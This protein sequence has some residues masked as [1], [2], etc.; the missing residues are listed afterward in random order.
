MSRV[1]EPVAL[2]RALDPAASL[3]EL[4]APPAFV[5]GGGERGPARP[6]RPRLLR[7]VVPVAAAVSVAVLV[8]VIPQA[9]MP[10]AQAYAAT[11]AALSLEYE[12]EAPAASDVLLGLAARLTTVSGT[13]GDGVFHYVRT[14]QWS[15][16]ITAG[17]TGQMAAAWIVP[18]RVELWRAADGSGRRIVTTLP[19]ESETGAP[20]DDPAPPA[21]TDSTLRRGGLA[22][23]VHDPVPTEP[24]LLAAALYAHQPKANGPKSAIRAVA[25]L[26]RYTAVR[27]E[28][29]TAVLA[30]LAGVPELRYHGQ[31]TD[32]LGRAGVAVGVDSD[33]GAVRDLLIVDQDTGVLLAYESLFLKR[34]DAVRVRVPAVFS[35]VLYL[36]QG[37]RAQP[38]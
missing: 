33:Q 37:W 11:P 6:V 27:R 15:L 12:D 13:E 36:E 5:P 38:R 2:L 24:T 14:K 29:R 9:D 35:Y 3:P 32:R 21:A 19:A 1:Q 28:A 8:A 30:F 31:V 10:A 26:Y 23:A 34:P 4:P 16:D 18:Q 25:D 20:V 7:G 17:R 22:A